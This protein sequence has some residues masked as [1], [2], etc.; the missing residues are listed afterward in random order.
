[1]FFTALLLAVF[2]WRKSGKSAGE[3]VDSSVEMPYGCKISGITDN[4]IEVY[5]KNPEQVSGYEVFRSYDEEEGY[6]CITVLDDTS[7]LSGR[8]HTIYY[9][10]AFEHDKRTVYYKVRSF[11]LGD[12]NEKAYSEFSKILK[13]KYRS[14]LE[15]EC[16][17]IYLPVNTSRKVDAYYGWGN[18]PDVQ[19]SSDDETVAEVDASG[20][21]TAVAKGTC[22]IICKSNESGEEQRCTVTVNRDP[23][24]PLAEITSRFEQTSPG[25]WENPDAEESNSA[26]IMMTGDMMCTSSQQKKQDG[27]TGDY[28]FNESFSLV[29]DIIAGSD[30][31][32]GNLETLIS[33]S[34]PYMREEAYINN[35]ANCNAP[36]RYLDA[37]KYAGFDGVVMSN[38][39]NCDGGE[40]GAI[41]TVHA[42]DDYRLARTGLFLSGEDPRTLLVNVNGIKV[43]FLSYTPSPPGF[44]GKDAGWPQESV[45][46]ILNYYDR[47]K[48]ETDIK[49]LRAQGA[50]YIIVYIHWGVKNMFEIKDNQKEAA[51]ELADLGADYIVGGHSH[52]IQPYDE[53]IARDGRVVPCFYSL[54]DF[55][56]SVNQIPGNRDSV[57]LRIG[58]A[59]TGSG[60]VELTENAYIPCYTYS[61]YEDMHYV[62]VPLKQELNGGAELK[63]YEKFRSRIAREVGD[64]LPEYEPE[65]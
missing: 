6:K 29:K 45:D 9:D 49:M 39:H 57:I 14:G 19:W 54:G 7:G 24:P 2:L 34:W 3:N 26:V 63:N 18:A 1:M 40:A 51:Q 20:T 60:E 8:S 22:N 23:L 62:T 48:A 42:V 50:E 47:E 28:N 61:K 12:D 43:G 21:I 33:S 65:A 11:L 37:L 59:K 52:L 4:G 44:N 17:V 41:E 10:T 38:N 32:I 35:I 31:A 36:A 5:W 53:V 56:S 58:L 64:K 30:F 15:L 46:T 16:T 25:C 27:G 55:N 13:A